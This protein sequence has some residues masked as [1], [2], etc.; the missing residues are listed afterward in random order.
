MKMVITNLL[1]GRVELDRVYSNFNGE[2]SVVRDLVYGIYIRG[3]GLPQ[4][5]GLA[6]AIWKSTLN[7]VLNY[8]LLISN[9]LIV[10]LGGGSIAKLVRKNWPDAKIT[11]VD[12]DPVMVELGKKYMNLDKHDVKIHIEDAGA[13]VKKQNNKYDLVCF[14]TYVGQNFPKKFESVRFIKQVEALLSKDGVVV[15]NRLYGPRER[16]AAIKFEITLNSVFKK[17]ERH[18]PEANIMFIC[19]S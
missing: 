7:K 11:G 2:L 17:I 15:F 1:E 14:D 6:E 8:K 3:G 16:D 5:G 18:Y 10:G 13:F 9:C 19:S 12:I 4:S